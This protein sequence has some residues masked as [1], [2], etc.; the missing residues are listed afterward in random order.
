MGGFHIP[1][2]TF[3][4][5]LY[6]PSLALHNAQPMWTKYPQLPWE[7]TITTLIPR[8]TSNIANVYA[9]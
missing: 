8:M 4:P 1:G 9:R 3:P 2:S 6:R 5:C 7:W